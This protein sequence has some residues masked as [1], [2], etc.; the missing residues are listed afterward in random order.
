VS[1]RTWMPGLY[2]AAPSL[3]VLVHTIDKSL[4]YLLAMF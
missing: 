4:L 3:R 2:T 1:S